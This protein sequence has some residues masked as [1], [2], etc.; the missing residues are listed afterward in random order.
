MKFNKFDDVV[1]S[2]RSS[3]R[4]PDTALERYDNQR[5]RL[6]CCICK[7][8]EAVV[9]VISVQNTTTLCSAS[10]KLAC[11]HERQDRFNVQRTPSDIRA[12]RL[13]EKAERLKE[14]ETE[15]NRRIEDAVNEIEAV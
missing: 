3:P 1:R 14:A 4:K 10:V 7:T 5:I 2:P 15:L 13:D 12:L 9:N 11:G 6:W 8:I